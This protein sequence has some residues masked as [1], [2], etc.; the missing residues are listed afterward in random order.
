MNASRF[1]S[2]SALMSLLALVSACGVIAQA[3][4]AHAV[5][6]NTF[7]N[8]TTSYC[9]ATLISQQHVLTARHCL[10]SGPATSVSFG[11]QIDHTR[12]HTVVH[13]VVHPDADLAVL[14]LDGPVTYVQPAAINTAKQ[15]IG[16]P[17]NVTGFAGNYKQGQWAHQAHGA[18][19][20]HQWY[21]HYGFSMNSLFNDRV[22]PGDSGSGIKDSNGDIVGVSDYTNRGFEFRS[23]GVTMHTYGQWVVDATG[24]T[25]RVVHNNFG[26]GIDLSDTAT[27]S[28][29]SILPAAPAETV[30]TSDA[31]TNVDTNTNATAPTNVDAPGFT[32]FEDT[33]TVPVTPTLV[34][35]SYSDI[36]TAVSEISVLV[37]Q[38]HTNAADTILE[39]EA[40]FHNQLAAVFAQ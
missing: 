3:S 24:G 36:A 22:I 30:S 9:S 23:G 4:P 7:L 35:P 37:Q 8:T 10:N 31:G 17:V 15:F 5:S 25:A 1:F 11:D 19:T 38:A 27:S 39:A 29:S 16:A 28:G 14:T 26:L 2:R 12:R 18:V 32:S 13:T 40:E 6:N 33:N 21:S 34:T 20:D